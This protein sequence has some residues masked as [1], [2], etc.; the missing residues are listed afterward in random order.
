MTI[1]PSLLQSTANVVRSD[2][3]IVKRLR[4]RMYDTVIIERI[5]GIVLFGP[6]SVCNRTFWWLFLML[7]LC[8]FD[9]TV[10]TFMMA[11][12]IGLSQISYLFS[13]KMSG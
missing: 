10:N 6:Q 8:T 11:I 5:I 13:L 12:V 2:W 7:S 3:V 4:H 9:V 1:L